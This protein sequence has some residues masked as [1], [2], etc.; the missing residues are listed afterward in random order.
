MNLPLKSSPDFA[1]LSADE[2]EDR[3]GR[4]RPSEKDEVIFYCRSGVRS[5]AAVEL[6]KRAGFGGVVSEFPGS[7]LEWEKNKGEVER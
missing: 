2:F 3:F 1:F 4:P 5:K 6:A 7:W